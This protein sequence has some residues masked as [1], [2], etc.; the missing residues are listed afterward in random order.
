MS[1]RSEEIRSAAARMSAYAPRFKSPP[2]VA[3]RPLSPGET[4]ADPVLVC[5]RCRDPQIHDRYDFDGGPPPVPSLRPVGS[6]SV[7]HW[8]CRA[9]GQVRLW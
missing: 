6:S 5:E 7:E 1:H 2:G 8:R 4:I 3:L 9:C